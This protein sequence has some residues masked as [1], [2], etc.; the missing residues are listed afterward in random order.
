MGLDFQQQPNP[1]TVK[2]NLLPRFYFDRSIRFEKCQ[3]I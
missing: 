3:I 1:K 2:I